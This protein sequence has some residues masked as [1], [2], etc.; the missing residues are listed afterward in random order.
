MASLPPEDLLPILVADL[1]DEESREVLDAAAFT[2]GRVYIPLQAGPI[3]PAKHLLEV[4]L[5]DGKEPIFYLAEPLGPPGPDGF[6]LRIRNA[7]G[8]PSKADPQ[9][10]PSKRAPKTSLR[11]RTSI[12]PMLSASHT[13][14][15][16]RSSGA[17]SS[18]KVEK[19][20]E[21]ALV[22]R[23]IANGKLKMEA[24]IGRG[25]VGA[26]YRARH[27]ELDMPVAVKVLHESFQHDL[28]FCRRFYAEALAASRLDH[29]NI[30]R[31]IDFGQEADGLLYFAMEFLDGVELR[32]LVD[33]GIVPAQRTAEIMMQVCAGLTQAHS[34]GI[35][36]RDIKPENIVL[37]SG[38]DDDGKPMDVVKVCDFGIAQHRQAIDEE[39]TT[40]GT[41]E[42]MSPEQCRADELDARSDV[43]AC[44]VVMY[45]MATGQ[46]PFRAPRPQS[47]LNK[48]QFEAPIAPSR[49]RPDI[50]PR[51]ERIILKALEKEPED[52]QGSM[53]DLRSEL[54]EL[55]ASNDSPPPPPSVQ[56]LEA[57][58]PSPPP[59]S[60]PQIAAPAWLER[61]PV[62][63]APGGTSPYQSSPSPNTPED[64]VPV[65]QD[66]SNDVTAFVQRLAKTGDAKAFALLI[67]RV[68]TALKSLAQR[69]DARAIWAVSSALR[70]IAM[71]GS[72]RAKIA[73]AT[74]RLFEDPA[75]LT[76]VAEQLLS[77]SEEIR[78]YARRML[79]QAGVAGAYGL[80]G[81]RV[82]L[83]SNATIRGPFVSVVKDFGPKAWP[84]VRASLEKMLTAPEVNERTLELAE[85]LLLCVPLVGDE[86]A[87]HLVV[88]YLRVNSSGVCRAAT[89]AIVKLWGERS[90]P[91]LVGMLQSKEDVV[92]IAG[93]AG[94]RQLDAIDEHIVPRLHALLMRRLP[95]GEELRAASAVALGHASENARPAAVS[96]L[97]QIVTPER[98]AVAP[99]PNAGALTRED[100][101]L[102][103]CARSLLAV[104][105][106]SYRGLVAERA[107]RSPDALKQQLKRLLVS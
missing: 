21:D 104:G 3:S 52:R 102:V 72:P 101:V 98:G 14:D 36:H 45:E 39:G 79:V 84:V 24:L 9:P 10:G 92:R 100:A 74:L 106:K 11:S 64:G 5:G 6:P 75:V 37:V 7:P 35:I 99:A 77:G 54:R 17:G 59:P 80:Y 91:L 8:A 48:H 33:K 4:H 81:A 86:S 55:L 41:P 32:K 46:T 20:Q 90:K 31:V 12:A 58:A 15:L 38:H 68:D 1:A 28:D 56:K 18:S 69:G 94:L 103:A 93:I 40:S 42:Y 57:A 60:S 76:A 23:A 34:R 29:A 49:V 51:L 44:G 73:E 22:G 88:K 85:D 89:A 65:A 83:A 95:A 107:E 47:L 97:S 87:G 63:A 19:S 67:Q 61:G 26:V 105:G 16:G 50:D 43:Y 96:L 82:K 78:E 27:R 62:Y 25:G 30:T 71:E 13:A 70:A 66:T 53:R 2:G